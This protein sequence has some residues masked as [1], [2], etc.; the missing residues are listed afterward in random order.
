MTTASDML[1]RTSTK[2]RGIIKQIDNAVD[3]VEAR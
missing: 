3:I 1:T 2:E